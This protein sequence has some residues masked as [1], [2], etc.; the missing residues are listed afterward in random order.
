MNFNLNRTVDLCKKHTGVVNPAQLDFRPFHSNSW[1]HVW[2]DE[3]A[4]LL[5]NLYLRFLVHL[6]SSSES[7]NSETVVITS[8]Q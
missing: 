8:M 1:C 5:F 6:L 7:V 3:R 2:I 4:A